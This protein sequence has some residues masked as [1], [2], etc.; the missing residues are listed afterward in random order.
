M[1]VLIIAVI[2]VLV[3]ALSFPLK[4]SDIAEDTLKRAAEVYQADIADYTLLDSA[5][6]NHNMACLYRLRLETGE[7]KT[8]A[9]SYRRHFLFPRYRFDSYSDGSRPDSSGILLTS[10]MPYDVAYDI[11]GN[12]LKFRD[13]ALNNTLVCFM[14]AS[15]FGII[16]FM[17]SLLRMW[18]EGKERK[19]Y[20]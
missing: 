17:F 13:S 11:S 14:L 12:V 10:G 15:A 18:L 1:T 5:Y 16:V 19:N 9:V 8:Y 7:E 4:E 2:A 20:T 3:S 6:S